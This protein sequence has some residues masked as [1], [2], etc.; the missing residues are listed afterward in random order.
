[1]STVQA[2][3]ALVLRIIGLV[4][5]IFNLPYLMLAA[6]QF[7]GWLDSGGDSGRGDVLAVGVYLGGAVLLGILLFVLA[8]PVARLIAPPEQTPGHTSVTGEEIVSIGSF[9]MGVALLVLHLPDVLLETLKYALA[10]MRDLDAQVFVGYWR[11]AWTA[12]EKALIL[13][14]GFWL[15]L[16]PSTLAGLYRWLRTAAPAQV[17]PADEA[18]KGE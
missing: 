8:R 6:A 15:V 7:M 1:M 14:I 12:A 3:G 13:L 11:D 17:E 4:V 16:R 9:L 5:I 10:L 2:I 18:P